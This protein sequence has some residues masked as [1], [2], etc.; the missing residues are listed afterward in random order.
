MPNKR[1]SAT[2]SQLTA[3]SQSKTR[4]STPPTSLNFWKPELKSTARSATWVSTLT[5]QTMPTRS[6]FQPTFPSQRDTW[7][8]WQRSTW[9]STVWESSCT[10]S[11][12]E[13]PVTKSNISTSNKK[14][15]TS[16]DLDSYLNYL[17]FDH[18]VNWA[19]WLSGDHELDL[20]F[21][22]YLLWEIKISTQKA[23]SIIT[24]ILLNYL[25]NWSFFLY[26]LPI[27]HIH[28]LSYTI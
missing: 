11:P 7:S 17:S 13:R 23:R 6:P 12:Q 8:I 1:K 3:P 28:H 15:R 19:R 2:T 24:L 14:V 22:S 25:R 18:R 27:L 20:N 9:R 5:C 26:F 21:Q 10:W 4:F 16:N